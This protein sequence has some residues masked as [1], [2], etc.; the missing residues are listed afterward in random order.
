MSNENENE[1]RV[2]SEGEQRWA[3]IEN[4]HKAAV[5]AGDTILDSWCI[6]D[7]MENN[8]YQPDEPVTEDQARDALRLV[9]YKYFDAEVGINWYSLAAATE[10]AVSAK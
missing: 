10:S 8:Q 1:D 9:S 7:V 4:R 2:L 3:D 6:A 5:I